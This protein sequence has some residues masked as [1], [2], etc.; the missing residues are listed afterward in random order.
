MS[1][2]LLETGGKLTAN[3]RQYSL[4]LSAADDKGWAKGAM[5]VCVPPG[6]D[7]LV[8]HPG[9][10]KQEPDEVTKFS[11]IRVVKISLAP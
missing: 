2:I 4:P 6:M 10:S 3:E 11:G 8:V 1:K 5:A 9:V 7:T